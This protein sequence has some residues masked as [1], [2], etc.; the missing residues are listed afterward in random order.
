[1]ED[2]LFEYDDPYK[3]L[4]HNIVGYYRPSDVIR[5]LSDNQFLAAQVQKE[6]RSLDVGGSFLDCIIEGILANKDRMEYMHALDKLAS[7]MYSRLDK[8]RLRAE[9]RAILYEMGLL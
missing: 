1:M 8:N 9:I 7:F 3:I 4:A 6:V 2:Y 5:M